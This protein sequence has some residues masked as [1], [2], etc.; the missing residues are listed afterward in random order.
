[1][2]ITNPDAT[3]TGL[4]A[5]RTHCNR[6]SYL[7][8]R[9]IA[10]PQTAHACTRK[11]T[12][13]HPRVRALMQNAARRPV[14]PLR[15]WSAQV[16]Q[17]Q[18]AQVWQHARPAPPAA[19]PAQP[20]YSTHEYHEYHALKGSGGERWTVATPDG[21][22]KA[23]CDREPSHRAHGYADVAGVG[24]L[25]AQMR[26][27][28]AQCRCRCGKGEFSPGQSRRKCARRSPDSD[29]ARL[30][31]CQVQ[32]WQGRAQS[33]AARGVVRR[34]IAT[35]AVLTQPAAAGRLALPWRAVLADGCAR[36]HCT[37]HCHGTTDPRRAVGRDALRALTVRAECDKAF[38]R[39][40]G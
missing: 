6:A 8:V 34:R 13:T 11:T 37:A 9:N 1:M 30:G 27:D 4:S 14:R 25:P 32:K 23:A 40:L 24:P 22:Q 16:Q 5:L 17:R 38:L 28:E 33:H 31:P 12:H 18:W 29:V 15:R 26:R 10:V 39:S 36:K 3:E 21:T 2:R 20:R 35:S 19:Q 7:R